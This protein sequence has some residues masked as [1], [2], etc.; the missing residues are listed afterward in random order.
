M[1]RKIVIVISEGTSHFNKNITWT[2]YS[3]C[4]WDSDIFDSLG[5]RHNVFEPMQSQLSFLSILIV[6]ALVLKPKLS[7]A[8]GIFEREN[9]QKS[10]KRENLWYFSMQLKIKIDHI[11]LIYLQTFILMVLSGY[12]CLLDRMEQSNVPYKL[13]F[14]FYCQA[15]VSIA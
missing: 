13:I 6:N 2:S 7:G 11:L 15:K 14:I 1:V 8:Q 4:E 10:W 12:I 5:I 9:K 3:F